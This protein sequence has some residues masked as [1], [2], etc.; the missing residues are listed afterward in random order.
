[1]TANQP[2]SPAIHCPL[3][4]SVQVVMTNHILT[5]AFFFCLACSKSFER[6]I[7]QSPRPSG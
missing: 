1:V 7:E 6:R 4:D 2:P 3:C 5:R